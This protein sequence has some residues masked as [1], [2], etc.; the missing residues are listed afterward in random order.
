MDTIVDDV[1]TFEALQSHSDKSIIQRM[2]ELQTLELSLPKSFT[3]MRHLECLSVEG[4]SPLTKQ[5]ERR[6]VL[7][8]VEANLYDTK[9]FQYV[10]VSCSWNAVN[11][12]SDRKGSFNIQTLDGQ[13]LRNE[14]RDTVIR[15]VVR[16]VQHHRLKGF[17]IDQ[18][19]LDQKDEQQ[20]AIAM[21]S[22][23]RLCA[24]S[25]RSVEVT[26][27]KIEHQWQIDV[28][29]CL[30]TGSLSRKF[31][32]GIDNGLLSVPIVYRFWRMLR[33]F[34]RLLSDG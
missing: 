26:M 21:H 4:A 27:T 10:T 16:Y 6:V 22:M 17:W 19:S 29:Y 34:V 33:W 32:S 20:Y 12:E 23:D 2:L 7:R 18:Q 14:V 13:R 11:G 8:E 30:L 9:I 28:L 5:N 24:D 1:K 25:P 31:Q 15:R 3:W